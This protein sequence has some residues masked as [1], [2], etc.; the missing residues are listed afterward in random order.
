MTSDCQTTGKKIIRVL[1]IGGN[2]RINGISSFIMEIYRRIDRE[3]IQ[4]DFVNTAS[5]PGYY[6]EEIKKLGGNIYSIYTNKEG[7]ARAI[8]H[9]RKLKN[10]LKH[11]GSFDV[12][13]SHYFSMNGLYLHV[14]K[15]MNVPVRISHCHQSNPY[16]ISFLKKI[17]LLFSR[18]FIEKNATVKLGCSNA[19]CNF[20]YGKNTS[21]T[22]FTGIDYDKFDINKYP[23]DEVYNKYKLNPK[24]KHLVFVGRFE[25]QKNLFFLLEFF[26]TLCKE[27]RN[28]KLILAGTGKLKEGICNK[29]VELGL[30]DK[31]LFIYGDNIV[32]EILSIADI[33]LLPSLWEGLGIVLLEAQAMGVPCLVSNLCPKEGDLGL[34]RFVPLQHAIWIQKINELLETQAPKIP[35]VSKEFCI[36]TT[37]GKILRCYGYK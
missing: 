8:T 34:C 15:S 21:Q 5:T 16:G 18:W 27:K 37:L 25:R 22:L 32:A 28:I 2:L 19:A 31:V 11:E 12:V 6:E 23:Q 10:I 17:A 24:D 9:A 36:D 26:A 30:Q 14:A 4:F 13:H 1:Q 20:L 33:F 35:Y 3:Q 7:L 29:V